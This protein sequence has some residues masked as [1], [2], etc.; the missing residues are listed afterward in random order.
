M[1]MKRYLSAFVCISLVIF[2]PLRAEVF[3][4][5]DG[6]KYTEATL[7]RVEPDGVV[8]S[9]SDGV[10]KLKFQNLPPEVC[11]KYGYNPESEV[12]YVAQRQSND[13][14][15]YQA[16]MPVTANPAPPAFVIPQS[17]RVAAIH[18]RIET[19][20]WNRELVKK[21]ISNTQTELA[22]SLGETARTLA[23]EKLTRLRIELAVAENK[24]MQ[25]QAEL[26]P[27]PTPTPTPSFFKRVRNFI[28]ELFSPTP[29][30]TPITTKAQ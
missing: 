14:A 12:K 27:K 9:Y 26:A 6:E 15:T 28:S 29:S 21:S 30:C 1:N 23:M 16:A 17:T 20:I 19:A 22:T 11:A 4:T 10:R 18:Q 24:L 8:I 13:V 2:T 7:K 25:A 3:T 5:L